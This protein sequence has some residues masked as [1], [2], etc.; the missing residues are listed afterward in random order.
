MITFEERQARVLAIADCH[1]D[2]AN[3][4]YTAFGRRAYHLSSERKK[5]EGIALPQNRSIGDLTTTKP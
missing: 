1:F 3:Y 5:Y 2:V 4:Q